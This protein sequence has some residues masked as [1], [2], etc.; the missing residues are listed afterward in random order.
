[1]ATRRASR[2]PLRNATARPVPRSS[3]GLAARCPATRPPRIC[4]PYALT[5]TP[6]SLSLKHATHA[7]FEVLALHFSLNSPGRLPGLVCPPGSP[8]GVAPAAR[9]SLTCGACRRTRWHTALHRLRHG[10]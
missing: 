1:M 7:P 5:L 6:T 9:L 8:R 3:S 2:P 10:E 4:A